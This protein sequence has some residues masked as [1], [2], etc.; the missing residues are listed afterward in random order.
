MARIKHIAYMLELNVNY[1]TT[2]IDKFN[3]SRF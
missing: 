1:R 3:I 2:I